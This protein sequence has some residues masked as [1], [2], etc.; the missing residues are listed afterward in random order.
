MPIFFFVIG[1]L[2]LTAGVRGTASQLSAQLLIDVKGF[3]AFGTVILILGGVGAVPEFRGIAKSF[4]LLVFVVFFLKN[5][6]N[7]VAN[8]QSDTLNVPTGTGAT[9]AAPSTGSTSSGSSLGNL[10]SLF[11]GSGST[12]GGAS[13][14]DAAVDTSSMSEM[15]D[16]ADLAAVA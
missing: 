9:S 6:K 14:T 5:G 13:A 4:L 12:S 1:V 2:M 16:I 10:S 3:L 7:V 15:S 11:G 8:I